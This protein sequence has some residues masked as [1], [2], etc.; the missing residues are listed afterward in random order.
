METKK[1]DNGRTVWD[2]ISFLKEEGA[3]GSRI[4]YRGQSNA[5]WKLVPALF[6]KPLVSSSPM[7]TPEHYAFI[8][9][10]LIQNFFDRAHLLLPSMDRTPLL[11]RVIA[12]HYG[13]P[14]QL[15]DWTVDPLIAIYFA[16]YDHRSDFD[17]AFYFVS[18]LRETNARVNVSFPHDGPIV[19]FFPPVIDERIQSQKSV[20]TIQDFGNSDQFVPIDDRTLIYRKPREGTHPRDQV[21]SIGKVVIPAEMKSQLV[22][23][24]SLIGVNSSLMYPGLAGIGQRIAD[25]VALKNGL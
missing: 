23:D 9:T 8:E 13:V 16:V 19:S 1:W 6:R 10:G 18:T 5:N 15:L 11:D 25:E 3:L 24:L 20:F 22:L 7:T 4:I 14:T 17:A 12:Q 21:S 2:L